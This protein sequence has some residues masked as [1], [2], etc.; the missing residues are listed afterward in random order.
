VKWSIN[1]NNPG[2]SAAFLT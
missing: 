2:I 1:A